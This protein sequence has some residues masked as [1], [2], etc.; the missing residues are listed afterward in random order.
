MSYYQ[1]W[2]LSLGRLVE[3][4]FVFCKFRLSPRLL[5]ASE[6]LLRAVWGCALGVSD[7]CTVVYILEVLDCGSYLILGVLTYFAVLKCN[8]K[9]DLNPTSVVE[10]KMQISC[11]STLLLFY[12][13]PLG[14]DFNSTS[15]PSWFNVETMLIQPVCVQWA[16]SCFCSHFVMRLRIFFAVL[17]IISCNSTH[18]S[19]TC[20]L[21]APFILKWKKFVTTKSLPR[22]GRPAKLR[23]QGRRALVREVTKNPMVTL[24][25]REPSRENLPE[26]QPSLQHSTN[27]AFMVE[28]PDGRHSSV[29]GTLGVCQNNSQ[30]MRNKI[31]WSDEAKIKLFG[32]KFWGKF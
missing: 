8:L 16:I 22:A 3:H 24:T 9:G 13:T 23:N 26:G 6:M 20:Y 15:I 30:T 28:W 27:Q 17:Q 10:E 18:F 32:L 7:N 4:L 11:N 29:K 21:G 5:Y 25:E 14:T 2:W 31:L 12:R 19:I 1:I